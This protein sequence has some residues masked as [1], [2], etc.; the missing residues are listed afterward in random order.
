MTC[1][2]GQNMYL[3]IRWLGELLIKLP[4]YVIFTL[5]SSILQIIHSLRM[6]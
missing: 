2:S 4:S 3:E 5:L 1:E 6:I